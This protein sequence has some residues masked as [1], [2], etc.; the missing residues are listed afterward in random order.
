VDDSP[1]EHAKP[2]TIELGS[3][4]SESKVYGGTVTTQA[5]LT[6]LLGGLDSALARYAQTRDA[7]DH[8]AGYRS[9]FE[10]CNWVYALDDRLQ[11]GTAQQWAASSDRDLVA[12]F[13]HA[14]NALQHAWSDGQA[15]SNGLSFP[16]E[17]PLRFSDYVWRQTLRTDSEKWREQYVA[18]LAGRSVNSTLREIRD[19]ISVAVESASRDQ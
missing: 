12:G 1:P 17:F 15:P 14:R 4:A 6:W 5:P 16:L 19:V 2:Q 8:E 10:A 3:V 9:L 13:R 18:R 7:T 11:G